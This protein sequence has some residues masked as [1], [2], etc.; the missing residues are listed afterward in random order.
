MLYDHIPW[1]LG[2]FDRNG[3]PS[4]SFWKENDDSIDTR[5]LCDHIP[6]MLGKFMR[7]MIYLQI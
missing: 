1:I 2:K 4:E 3:L 7:E 5:L 6:M